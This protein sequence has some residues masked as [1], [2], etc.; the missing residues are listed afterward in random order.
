MRSRAI[1]IIRLRSLLIVSIQ[2]ELSDELVVS[3]KENL[4]WELS[5]SDAVGVVIELSG[6]D[7]FDSFIASSIG[8]I[9]RVVRLM[10]ADTV[11]AGLDPAMAITLVEM[12]MGIGDVRTTLNLDAA[13]TYLEDA[14]R[15]KHRE[16]E[17]LLGRLLE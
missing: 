3:L 15:A 5:T 13:F 11:V 9:A 4:A 10:G 12:G 2:T 14:A 7:I 17:A 16:D 6:V 8:D 1:P